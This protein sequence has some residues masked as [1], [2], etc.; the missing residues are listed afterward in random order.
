MVCAIEHSLKFRLHSQE[1]RLTLHE[2]VKQT[3]ETYTTFSF[4][5]LEEEEDKGLVKIL[6]QNK[7]PKY[8]LTSKKLPAFLESALGTFL[9]NSTEDVELSVVLP[10]APASPVDK[11]TAIYLVVNKNTHTLLKTC[12]DSLHLLG[13]KMW[14][15][16][17]SKA[18]PD[19]NESMVQ[20]DELN[21]I[22]ALTIRISKSSSSKSPS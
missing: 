8:Y 1:Q 14:V 9:T 2:I 18:N 16:P 10:P 17:L 20:S 22:G 19:M 7:F 5:D 4:K 11:R 21:K 15:I 12:T 13:Y 6:L 3:D